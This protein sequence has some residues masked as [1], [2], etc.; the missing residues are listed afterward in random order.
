M[1]SLPRPV[2][3]LLV[4]LTAGAPLAAQALPQARRGTATDVYGGVEVADPY[5]WME[6][7]DSPETRAWIRAQDHYA[8]DL[9][10]G[11]IRDRLRQRIA[12]ITSSR[13][14]GTPV[15][16]GSSYFYIEGDASFA[17]RTI[18]QATDTDPRRVVVDP[19]AV[20]GDSGWRVLRFVPSESGRRIAYSMT[21][22]GSR[23]ET[24]RVR[25]VVSRTDHPDR[26]IGLSGGRSAVVWAADDLGFFYERFDAPPA[27]AELTFRPT[28]ER[29]FWHRLGTSQDDD[30]VVY[31]PP[32]PDHTTS[33]ARSADG[34]YL[35]VAE[36]LGG[37]PEN[38]ILV[39]DLQE[40]EGDFRPLV[41]TADGTY[42]YLGN[43][44]TE[45]WLQTTAGADRGRV[46]AVD[47]DHPERRRWI[48]LIPESPLTID[49]TIGVT[50]VGDR[51]LVAYRKDAW[52]SVRVFD[53]R[54]RFL[55]DLDLPKVGS[56]WT[57]FVGRQDVAEAFYVLTTF[58][59]PGTVYRLDVR[60]GRSE[61]FRRPAL[62]YD[63]D[64]FVTSQ[65]FY[66]S[67]DGTR[68]P[69]FL[70]HR[71]GL[72]LDGRNPTWLYGYGAFNWSA[73][74]WF[75]AH[76]TVWMEMGGVHALPGI[77]G[78]GEYGESWHRAGSGRNEQTSID[79]Y[80]A[81]AT[82]LVDEGY[83]APD[84]LVANGGSASGVLAA[85]AIVQRP[86]LFAASLIEYPIIDMLRFDHFT[87]GAQWRP[88]FGST[89]DPDD[90]RALLAYS[91]YQNLVEGDCYPAT[92]ITPGE[93]DEVT[94]PMHAYKF[95]AALQHA[96]GCDHPILLRVSWGAGHA[97]GVTAADAA[98]TYADQLAFLARTLHLSPSEEESGRASD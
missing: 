95:A 84:R 88:E 53:T 82:W 91:P 77:R 41:D 17:D 49:P 24:W 1:P 56:V 83:T 6:A 90:V 65:V 20:A 63:P 36:A 45:F 19:A 86:D 39:R 76:I 55:Y 93:R 3:L 14:F 66:R 34:R 69:M 98:D 29:V 58:A 13:R 42:I 15:H 16:R 43:R 25:D 22:P 68:I 74:P 10:A 96:Q 87:G 32:A 72:V 38:R 46:I 27:G 21:R 51:F 97:A 48:E 61:V 70:T 2:A 81:A 57:G 31:T 71:K 26:L 28:N 23:W 30:R 50:A 78:G 9:V 89:E 73:A 94:V 62:G 5:R 52:L 75:Q 92:L 40:T 60:T 79:D 33:L 59:D 35:V 37:A 85:A 7:M 47:R 64:Q 80:L 8:R 4:A 12:T 44:G 18:V 54:G 11:P 67:A